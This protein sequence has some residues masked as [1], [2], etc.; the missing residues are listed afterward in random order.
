ML[1]IRCQRIRTSSASIVGCS[2]LE[3]GSIVTVENHRAA[4]DDDSPFMHFGDSPMFELRYSSIE[5]SD[6]DLP[7]YLRQESATPSRREFQ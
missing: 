2:S 4:S 5:Q 1:A 7:E 3:G 6:Y